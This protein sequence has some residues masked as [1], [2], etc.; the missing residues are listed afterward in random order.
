MALTDWFKGLSNKIKQYT[1]AKMMSGYTPVFS[2]FGQDIYASDIVQICISKTAKEI[3]K[4]Q[5]QHIR[6]DADGVQTTPKGN[7]NRLFKFKPNPLMTTRDFL[8][9]VI[10]LLFLNYNCFI[11]PTYET[12]TDGSGRE[13]RYYT[14]FYPLNPTQVDFLQ[15]PSNTLYVRLR[16]SGG[17]Q[18][19]VPYS[20][21]IHLRKGFSVNDIMGGGL[22]GQ[23]D[24]AALLKV[25]QINH[26]VLQGLEKGIKTSMSVRGIIKISTM[27]DDNGQKAERSRFER[28]MEEGK[29]GIM[30][31]DL[32]GDFIPVNLDP[33]LIDKDTA[34]FLQSK[35]LN[36][37]DM[38][39]P[40]LTGDFT[41]EQYQAWYEIA[42]EPLVIGL[43]Q[44]FSS[45]LF[46]PREQDTGNEVV[47]YQRNM[48]YLSTKAKIELLKIAG[49][50][51]L[52]TDNQKLAL[53]GYPPIVGGD[54]RT[55][56]LNYIDVTLINQ[57][58]LQNKSTKAVNED[59]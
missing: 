44:A 20:D 42:L 34:E 21:I 36:W 48:M 54:R 30:P 53:I 28:L 27:L 17:D 35:V 49:E 12:V 18:V 4:L 10:W 3:S 14:G 25:L 15:D 50:Q 59:E 5:P 22:N 29:S 2:Q 1:Y 6:T 16:F 51:G 31:L 8:E 57:Y 24:N 13:S 7:I 9:K 37:F 45:V 58:Q 11:Y 39:L 43:G 32:K 19:T 26:V 40:I 56:S 46:T 55:Q 33:K 23:P 52:M 38:P 47:F 41:D